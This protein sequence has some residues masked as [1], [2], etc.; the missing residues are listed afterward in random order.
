M[1]RFMLIMF[2]ATWTLL[3]V[4]CGT[5]EIPS[6]TVAQLEYTNKQLEADLSWAN[7]N[8]ERLVEKNNDLTIQ[9][10]EKDEVVA[11][12]VIP[13]VEEVAEIKT[14]TYVS[15]IEP[16][17]WFDLTPN[18]SR[19]VFRA[20]TWVNFMNALN[21]T[22]VKAFEDSTKA[23]LTVTLGREWQALQNAM[24]T[25]NVTIGYESCKVNEVLDR[26]AFPHTRT[27]DL[28]KIDCQNRWIKNFLP[29]LK[30][31]VRV[32]IYNAQLDWTSYDG[33]ISFN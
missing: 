24:Y 27:V 9:L 29:L 15:Q 2:M 12:V 22:K 26:N 25:W 17:H 21:A 11:E 32:A 19:L 5:K 14:T 1:K 16:K 6:E 8:V 4:G 3:L 33:R 23:I 10:R 30:E 28:T 18:N 13:V 20:I 7:A 31:W